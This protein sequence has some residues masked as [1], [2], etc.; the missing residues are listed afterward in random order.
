[1]AI[2]QMRIAACCFFGVFGGLVVF[3][4][5]HATG[6][7]DDDSI[8]SGIGQNSE[9]LCCMPEDDC[10]G[11]KCFARTGQDEAWKCHASCPVIGSSCLQRDGSEGACY[12]TSEGPFCFESGTKQAGEACGAAAECVVGVQCL[13]NGGMFCWQVCAADEDCTEPAVCTDTGLGFS[14]C[15]VPQADGGSW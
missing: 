9:C 6:C 1:M 5:G 8:D 7:N 11:G 3:V 14:V 13:D 12:Y 4:F 2:R 15:R 10:S